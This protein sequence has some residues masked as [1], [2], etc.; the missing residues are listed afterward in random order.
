[1]F[2]QFVGACRSQTPRCIGMDWSPAVQA[3]VL[4]KARPMAIRPGLFGLDQSPSRIPLPLYCSKPC[5]HGCRRFH[6]YTRRVRQISPPAAE[7]LRDK[8]G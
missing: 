2:A 1:M 8:V 4:M 6:N 5:A 7:A 3:T